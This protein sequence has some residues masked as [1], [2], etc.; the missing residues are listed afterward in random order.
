MKTNKAIYQSPTIEVIY[1]SGCDDVMDSIGI[2][3]HSGGSVDGGG[4]FNNEEYVD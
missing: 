1:L 3:R 2:V 4:S